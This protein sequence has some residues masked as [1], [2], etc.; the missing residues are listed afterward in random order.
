MEDIKI[1]YV[2]II[3]YSPSVGV[4]S[5]PAP[6]PEQLHNIAV[7]ELKSIFGAFIVYSKMC[8]NMG[9]IMQYEIH[10]GLFP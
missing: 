10:G 7:L 8:K 4:A 6:A 5:I 3:I 9:Q 2:P 1:K